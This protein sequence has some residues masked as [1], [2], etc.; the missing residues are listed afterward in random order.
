MTIEHPSDVALSAFAAGT[1]DE[2]QPV[3]IV[4]HLNECKRCP[5]FV[6]AVEQVGGIVLDGLPPTPLADGSLASTQAMFAA[7]RR[8]SSSVSTFACRPSSLRK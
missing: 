8:A 4:K 1:H 5:V 7:I 6:H 2:A 3:A